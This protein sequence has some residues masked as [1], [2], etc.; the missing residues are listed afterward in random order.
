[1][2]F[3]FTNKS[4]LDKIPHKIKGLDNVFIASSWQSFVS[5]LPTAASAGYSLANNIL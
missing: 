5:G 3:S 1:M 2:G 4:K